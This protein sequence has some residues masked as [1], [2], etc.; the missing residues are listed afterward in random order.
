MYFYFQKYKYLNKNNYWLNKTN[1]TELYLS[2]KVNIKANLG[3]NNLS[4]QLKLYLI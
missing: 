4:S 2:V 1:R 3:S